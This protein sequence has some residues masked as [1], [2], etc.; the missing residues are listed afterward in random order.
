LF[1]TGPA[2]L[3][4]GLALGAAGILPRL[5]ANQESNNPG[6][7]YEDT[8]GS[9][10]YPLHTLASAL[11]S[12]MDDGHAY[13]GTSLWGVVLVL[14][15]VGVLLM[16]RR[17]VTPF[18]A[19]A[20][21]VIVALAMGLWPI[22]D[23]FYLLPFYEE[24]HTHSP[25]R[26]FWILPFI[27]AMLAGGGVNELPRLSALRWKWLVVLTPAVVI[28]IAAWYVGRNG[29][30]VGGV[31]LWTCVIATTLVIAFVAIAPVLGDRAAQERLV[32]GPLALLVALAFVLPNGVDL[33]KT[34]RQDDPPPGELAMWG[35][36][37]WMQGIIEESLAREDPGGAGEFLQQQEATEPPF[38]FIAYGGMYHP[39]TIRETYPNRRLEPA[40]IAILQ[41]SRPMRLGLETTQGYN[42][43]QPMV[44]QEFMAALNREPQDYHYANLIHTGVN[45]PLLDLLNVRY[46]VVDRNI[47]EDRRDHRLL[48]EIRTEVYR[49]DN[50]IIYESS[51]V[52]PRAWM[53]YDVRPEEDGAGLA[54]LANGDV[55]GSQ[56]AFVEGEPP[57]AMPPPD[58]SLSTVTST[59][60]T[61][62]SRTFEV[63][64]DGQGLLV[65]SEVWSENWTATVD[66]EEAEVLQTDHALL[67]IPVGPG[68]HTVVVR[69]APDSLALGLWLS[70]LGALG[71]IAVLGY[72]GWTWIG[73][74]RETVAAAD[75]AAE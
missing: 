33:V 10:D 26:V 46:I 70:G 35:N 44:Y 30:A 69:Y 58:G 61:E 59:G 36:D 66:G 65:V 6:G 71:A 73:S 63:S 15:L 55:D 25:G 60:W 34:L 53:V 3:V 5:A 51:T 72:A 64:H 75:Q 8:P 9:R 50:V 54:A 39:D 62:D 19:V 52:Q 24:M 41:N 4:I 42:P 1:T 23:L 22:A 17:A 43:L 14:M 21:V 56:V 31:W 48:A 27:A 18:F 40:M 74:R 16:R 37:A 68:E 29:D 38:R 12:L 67:G 32:L 57:A 49:D 7:T 28:A 47:P 2:I 11:R 45:S 20:F 13:R